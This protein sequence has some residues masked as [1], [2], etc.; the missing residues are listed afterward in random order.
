MS[1]FRNKNASD[2]AKNRNEY[3][4]TLA[5]Q[6][7]LND[8]NLQANKTYLLSGQLPPASQMQDT[9]TAS[10]KLKDV[11]TMKQNIAKDLYDIAEPQFAYAI[12][13]KVLN[14]PLN[15]NNSL[16]RFLSQRAK[17]INEQ[18][19]PLYTYKIE[20]DTNDIEHIVNFIKNM[21]SNTQG[22]FQSV[23]SYVN[24]QGNIS[25]NSR[26]INANDI[27]IIISGISEIIKNLQIYQHIIVDR[28]GNI[29]LV[30]R[31]GDLINHLMRLK[32]ILPTTY[33]LNRFMNEQ[34]S[35]NHINHMSTEHYKVMFD[36]LE[37]KLPRYQD[38]VTLV[39]KGK[40]YSRG[41]QFNLFSKI[42][43][44][45]NQ[46]FGF[47]YDREY[48]QF[49]NEVGTFK[50]Y[51]N[52][53]DI[54]E[55]KMQETQQLQMIKAQNQ[56]EK[57]ES[58]ATKVFV[59][60]DPLNVNLANNPNSNQLLSPSEMDSLQTGESAFDEDISHNEQSIDDF[61]K[62]LRDESPIST[63][64]FSI[65]FPR[66]EDYIRDNY[67][68]EEYKGDNYIRDERLDKTRF[69]VYRQLINEYINDIEN[70]NITLQKLKELKRKITNVLASAH[71]ELSNI[72]GLDELFADGD[73]AL[74]R[75]Y[76]LEND[77]IDGNG[78]RKIKPKRRSQFIGFGIS[79][80]NHKSLENNI[81]KIRRPGSKSN[82]MDLPSRRVSP[83]MKNIITRISGGG[84][85]DFDDLS[86]LDNDE[87]KYLNKLLDKADLKGR[88]SIPAP[89]K[90]QEEKEIH[91]FEVLKGQI[92]SGN[93]NKEFVKKFKLV[94]R[95]LAHKQLLPRN[96]V[97]DMIEILEDMGY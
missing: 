54:E 51:E 59:M 70:P 75:I 58:R 45:I 9:R 85:P 3:M 92:M 5:M 37:N 62:M 46:L 57:D 30:N 97:R 14:S 17:Q 83:H 81:V 13:N 90:D 61:D 94:M 49:L 64:N 6:E 43:E 31:T 47:L 48:N 28:P 63:P 4:A 25:G 66:K 60:N 44:S 67:D 16:F 26:V 10:E 88:L 89:S 32:S 69:N 1:G 77:S 19:K 22:S 72:D 38:V 95:K 39:N 84:I 23:K 78:I 33:Q 79:E 71:E 82:Y 40:Q 56:R 55:S 7:Q 86:K 34:Q 50:H 21:Y 74:E 41:G 29:N 73:I 12:V 93:D 52:Q 15:V 36:F 91:E 68:G 8:M 42:L 24:S 53:K 87:K 20:G 96:E 18:L 80:I 65:D 2:I 76:Q 27:D 35:A 11:E